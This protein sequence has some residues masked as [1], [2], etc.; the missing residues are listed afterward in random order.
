[1][2]NTYIVSL[3]IWWSLWIEYALFIWMALTVLSNILGDLGS[4][5]HML[6]FISLLNM[7]S[8]ISK[9]NFTLA[10]IQSTYTESIYVP[11]I[12]PAVYYAISLSSTNIAGMNCLPWVIFLTLCFGFSPF[13]LLFIHLSFMSWI[14][15]LWDNEH[16]NLDKTTVHQ[17]KRCTLAYEEGEGSKYACCVGRCNIISSRC[18]ESCQWKKTKPSSSTALQS[19]CTG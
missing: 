7:I 11:E 18:Q 6:F 5:V 12:S 16:R 4:L 17:K 14:F 1:M 8:Y 9:M 2:G 15:F 13:I 10:C 3:A 19:A